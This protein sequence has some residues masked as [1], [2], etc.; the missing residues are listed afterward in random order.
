MKKYL[1]YARTIWHEFWMYMLVGPSKVTYHTDVDKLP[2]LY[3]PKKK[4]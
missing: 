2:E 3:K 1:T 4:D